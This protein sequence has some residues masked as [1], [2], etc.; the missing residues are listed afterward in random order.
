MKG[1]T[2]VREELREFEAGWVPWVLAAAY[3]PVYIVLDFLAGDLLASRLG[4][5]QSVAVGLVSLTVAGL[6]VVLFVGASLRDAAPRS[7]HGLGGP[8]RSFGGPL[9]R[10]LAPLT[11][12][13]L[14]V[15]VVTRD[16]LAFLLLGTWRV[17]ARSGGTAYRVLAAVLR[18]VSF[19]ARVITWPV[20]A[21]A[22][23]VGGRRGHPGPPDELDEP[24]DRTALE[25]DSPG[26]GPAATGGSGPAGQE[27]STG[28]NPW[29]DVDE[30]IVIE[31][32]VS[33]EQAL[34][35]AATG[36]D[37]DRA[38][39]A[40][41]GDER[42]GGGA[43]AAERT[44]D[45]AADEGDDTPDGAADVAADET[46]GAE[47]AAGSETTEA[48]T[49]ADE[50]AGDTGEEPDEVSDGGPGERDEGAARAGDGVDA[51]EGEGGDGPAPVDDPFDDP[52][53]DGWPEGWISASD[54]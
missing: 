9:R 3:F 4:L 8:R 36:A 32:P 12:A 15:I 25:A 20:E 10:L 23:S 21:V 43:P 27:P 53:E 31:S 7:S 33:R 19:L 49:D 39:E 40:P 17:V 51:Q 28:G 16:A 52:D 41:G 14:A 48:G 34:A 30:A 35:E 24:V 38:E 45:A 37:G 6:V 46:G 22:G 50:F 13:V 18:P 11:G 2:T 5:P 47:G 1:D 42:S 29:P 54:V 26:T 44:D